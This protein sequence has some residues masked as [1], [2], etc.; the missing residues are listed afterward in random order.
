M[1]NFRRGAL[2]LT[3]ALAGAALAG[4][5]E[6]TFAV[7]AAKEATA[8]S[9]RQQG[10]YKVGEPYQINGVWYHPAEDYNYDETGIA[11]YYGGEQTGVNF[12]GRLTANG[13]VYDMNSLTAAHR[14][15][16]MPCLVRVTNLENGRAIVVRVNDRGPYARGRIIDMSRRA[17]Q[18]LGFE[19]VGTARVRVQILAQESRQLKEAMLRGAAP[20]GTEYVAAVPVGAVQSNELAPP[21]GARNA[22]L[23]TGDALPPPS[24]T[25]GPASNAPPPA[26]KS[27]RR[28]KPAVPETTLGKPAA[29]VTAQGTDAPSLPAGLQPAGP[30]ALPSEVAALPV[31][32]QAKARAT[33]TQT[34]VRPTAMFVQAGAFSSFDNATRLSARLSRYGHTQITQVN[35]NGQRLYRVR[36][37]PVASVREADDILDSLATEAPQARIVVAD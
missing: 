19:G 12:H 5:A 33:V 34:P 15:L 22:G 2:L 4:C 18:L 37:G 28:G 8:S 23:V 35:A 36:I 17:A 32:E 30:V 10:I 27:A 13:E 9:N 6:T 29:P 24:A 16:P 7:N 31:P 20:P 1:R 3:T 11:S 26:S 25:L 21:P 14:T